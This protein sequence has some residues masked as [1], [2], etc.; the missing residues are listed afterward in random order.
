[1]T[2]ALSQVRGACEPPLL[3]ETIGEALA[4]AARQWPD[5]EA[6]VSCAE[7]LRLTFGELDREAT[8]LAA[9]L[10]ALGLRPGDRIGIWSPNCAAWALTQFAAARAGLILVTINPAY[11]TS[12]LEHALR[13]LG[14]R[15]L[16][17]AQSFKTSDYCAMLEAIADL[18]GQPTT[19]SLPRLPDLR[20]AIHLGQSERPGWMQFR[21]IL[22]LGAN[23]AHPD[24]SGLELSADDPI[25]VQFTSGTTGV[26][27]GATLTHS[28]IL[29]N[30]FFVGNA[31]GVTRADRVCIPVPL[32][33]CFGMVL[34]NLACVVHG[35]AMV[36]PGPGF[37][38][39]AT[40]SALTKERCTHVY[41]VP[42]MF[43]AILREFEATGAV[44]PSLRG[45]IM[46]G[47]PCPAELMRQVIDMLGMRDVCI[48]YG[49][50]ETSPVSFQTSSTDP[51]ETRIDTVGR[52]QP[53]LESKLVTEGGKVVARGM[54]GELCTRGYSV[55]RGYWGDPERTAKAIDAEG[56]MH[57]G[58]VATIDE[59]GYCRIIGRIKDMVIRGG[60]NIYPREVEDF[61]HAHPDVIDIAVASEAS[62]G[63]RVIPPEQQRRSLIRRGAVWIGCSIF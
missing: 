27:K 15:T 37:D 24:F 21:Q 30:A 36:Y 44:V 41:G 18:T 11:R 56:W 33:H 28:N 4:K 7:S 25:N 6:L 14:V 43:I 62:C 46:A 38:A 22:E 19:L 5:D 57:S 9:G 1:V 47:A 3:A 26:P 51:F 48:A 35:A 8:R 45:G 23:A 29:N 16:I 42:T 52:V 40:L 20:H 2:E 12:E 60:E 63:R 39:V 54:P 53:H 61:F 31:A 34:G 58:D 17:C 55:M 50:T 59:S 10:W 32:Y 49:M 13:T